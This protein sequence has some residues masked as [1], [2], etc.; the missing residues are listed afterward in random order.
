MHIIGVYV[1]MGQILHIAPMRTG[2]L[3]F[4]LED[5]LP[6]GYRWMDVYDTTEHPSHV[7]SSYRN[8]LDHLKLNQVHQL[9]LKLSFHNLI[10]IL[11]AITCLKPPIAL[12]IIFYASYI[13]DGLSRLFCLIIFVLNNL[14]IILRP[15]THH[16]YF[17]I[18]T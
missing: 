5:P 9:N 14:Y 2:W 12:F 16:F 4:N 11:H 6:L 17:Y 13:N 3:Q 18:L 15:L 8:A 10:I 1:G 7:I